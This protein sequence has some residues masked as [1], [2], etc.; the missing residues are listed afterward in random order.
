MLSMV[1]IG[2]R[3]GICQCRYRYV[4]ANNKLMKDYDKNKESSYLKYWGVN[5]L[6]G[7][8][9]RQKLRA[10][11][12]KWVENGSQ[13]SKDFIEK[14]N[15]DSEKYLQYSEKLHDLH[16]DLPFL[17]KRMVIWKFEKFVASSHDKK[18][19]V[20]HIRN[21]KQALTHGL[22]LEKLNIESLNLIK[23]D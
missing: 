18:E 8:A 10:G 4:K 12:F 5:N 23:L 11:C 2:F 16:N 6:Y 17:P 20:I 3:G 9:M 1:E 15:E 19:H 22:V 13:L 21:L 14:H 7:W